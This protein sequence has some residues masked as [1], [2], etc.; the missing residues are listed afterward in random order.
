M[1]SRNLSDLIPEA[2]DKANLFLEQLEERGVNAL[3][4]CTLRTPEEQIKLYRQSRSSA[5]IKQKILKLRGRGFGFVA[6]VIEKVGPQKTGRHVTN[7]CGYE[8]FHNL[9]EAFDAVPLIGGK[10]AW[11]YSHAKDEWDTMGIVGKCVGLEWGGYW[12]RFVDRPHFQLRPGGNPL[13]IYAPEEFQQLLT[14][15]GLLKV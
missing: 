13:K 14:Q 12:T 1:A 2:E 15:R 10:P 8:S 7:A 6:D 3:I 4:Y 5:Q 9:A 11:N